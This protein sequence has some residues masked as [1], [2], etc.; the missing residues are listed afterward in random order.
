[1]LS[2][3]LASHNQLLHHS[4]IL[5]FATIIAVPTITIALS[6]VKFDAEFVDGW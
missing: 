2:V 1:M 4:L 5:P 3:T 6:V